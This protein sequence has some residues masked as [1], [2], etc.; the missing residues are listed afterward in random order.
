MADAGPQLDK[1]KVEGASKAQPAYLA[2][3][4]GGGLLVEN[5]MMYLQV[6]PKQ[7]QTANRSRSACECALI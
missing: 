1:R 3:E 2:N 6:T 5:C 4:V 7:T